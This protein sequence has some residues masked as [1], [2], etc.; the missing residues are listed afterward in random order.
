M[1]DMDIKI[2]R[3]RK[4]TG[5]VEVSY[6]GMP[7]VAIQLPARH[8]GEAEFKSLLQDHA[9]DE[10]AVALSKIAFTRFNYDVVS[11]FQSG[12]KGL[13]L[14]R[15]DKVQAQVDVVRHPPVRH[16]PVRIHRS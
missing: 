3:L 16:P 12:T 11:E 7:A 1:S 10:E 8:L 15:K 6:E 14:A 4:E 13:R 5:I 9:P 2:I